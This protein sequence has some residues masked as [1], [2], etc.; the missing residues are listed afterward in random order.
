MTTAEMWIEDVLMIMSESNE[1][2]HNKQ[3]DETSP[4]KRARF[5]ETLNGL[6]RTILLSKDW[7]TTLIGLW[8][9]DRHA[10]P[11]YALRR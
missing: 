4:S 8:I 6:T 2:N 5:L 9:H 10:P 1:M 7:N 3:S 11:G